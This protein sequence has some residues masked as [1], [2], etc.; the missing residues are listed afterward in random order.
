MIRDRSRGKGRTRSRGRGRGR[1]T[2]PARE[3]TLE[4]GITEVIAGISRLQQAIETLVG[5]M[6]RPQP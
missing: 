3:P 4:E 5:I 1:T 2:K 6:A